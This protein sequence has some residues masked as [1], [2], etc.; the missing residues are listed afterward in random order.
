MQREGQSTEHDVLQ[1]DI[2]RKTICCP[3]CE[4]TVPATLYCLKCGHPL[5]NLLGEKEEALS[6]GAKEFFSLDPLK[7]I[8]DEASQVSDETA[9]SNLVLP[10]TNGM[11]SG[12]E[13]DLEPGGTDEESDLNEA[14]FGESVVPGDSVSE[15]GELSRPEKMLEAGEEMFVEGEQMT[16]ILE[17]APHQIENEGSR[18]ESV[19]DILVEGKDWESEHGADP[20]IAELAKELMN[21]ISLQL[22]SVNLLREEGVDEDHFG[23]IFQGYQARFERCM[24]QRNEMLE[25]ARDTA[26]FEKKANEAKVELGELEVRRSLGDLSEGEYEAMTPA[27]RWIVDHNEDLIAGR[28]AEIALLE[29]LDQLM[30]ADKIAKMRKMAETANEALE[31]LNDS[32]NIGYKTVSKIRASLEDIMAYLE[33]R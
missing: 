24:A 15:N 25:E 13:L 20:K 27:L 17:P 11:R 10:D 21:S 6:E 8:Q 29:D 31:S 33:D 1:E 18:N 28:K 5:F 12:V 32:E 14:T 22:W 2:E 19:A 4:D 3:N 7:G 16:G 23:R 9:D 30:P 26:T